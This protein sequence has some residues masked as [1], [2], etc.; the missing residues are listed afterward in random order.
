MS[1]SRARGSQPTATPSEDL[2]GAPHILTAIA[3]VAALLASVALLLMGNGLQSTLLPVR[4]SLEAF[5]TFQIGLLGTAYYAG[6]TLGCLLGAALIRQAGHIRCFM[7]MAS[8][9]SVV[10][11]LHV[12]VVSPL[13]WWLLRSV[14]GFC[15]AVLYIIIESW[16]NERSTNANRGTVFSVYIVINLTVITMGQLMMALADP[17]DFALF[18]LSSVLVSLAVLPIAFTKAAS[19]D[20]VPEIQLN[21]SKLYRI[22]PLGVIGCLAVGF[23]NGSFWALGPLF[24]SARGMTPAEVGL[25]MSAVVV[26]GAVAQAPLG[27]LSDRMDRRYMMLGAALI[28][29]VAAFA[30]RW[31]QDESL[32]MLLMLSFVFGAGAFPLYALSVAHANDHANAGDMVEVSSGL[33]LVHSIGS[34]LG[35]VFAAT[36]AGAGFGIT[37]FVFIALVHLAFT[38]LLLWRLAARRAANEDERATFSEVAVAAQT[39]SPIDPVVETEDEP[40]SEGDGHAARAD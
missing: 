35:P 36:L 19:P 22:S 23:A 1:D 34:A 9:A 39:F 5:P 37:L 26:G 4:G 20:P 30:L 38:L 13:A 11:L 14:A 31:A 18:A 29:I 2:P 7:A 21:L 8:L 24:A 40:A 25:F 10:A 17:R 6:F 27:M 32:Q 16:L 12:V 33:L 3:P 28:A 15:F